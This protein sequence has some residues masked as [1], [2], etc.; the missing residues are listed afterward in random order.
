MCGRVWAWVRVFDSEQE[1]NS[2]VL[3]SVSVSLRAVAA[4]VS[5]SNLLSSDNNSTTIN[6][7][8]SNDISTTISNFNKSVER[9]FDIWTTE[10]DVRSLK[11]SGE[12]KS[13]L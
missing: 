2:S 4:T 13:F 12:K 1:D 11:M 8:N 5:V 6:D 7:N 10:M 9:M 3:K